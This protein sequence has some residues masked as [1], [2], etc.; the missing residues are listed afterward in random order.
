M[1][2]PCAY[3]LP[4]HMG[5]HVLAKSVFASMSACQY[6]ICGIGPPRPTGITS[7]KRLSAYC[8]LAQL[9]LPMPHP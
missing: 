1:A 9:P 7:F 8:T 6:I 2:L 5:Y 3:E 4:Y